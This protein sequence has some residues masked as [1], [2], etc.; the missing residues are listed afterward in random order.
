M[1]EIAGSLDDAESGSASG[2]VST[3]ASAS[4]VAAS[5]K[6]RLL[7]PEQRGMANEIS[8]NGGDVEKQ[9]D[10]KLQSQKGFGG[11]Q[12]PAASTPLMR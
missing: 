11:R 6:R 10:A 7:S 5:A 1:R 12:P 2:S 3:S 8:Y 9:G 4:A